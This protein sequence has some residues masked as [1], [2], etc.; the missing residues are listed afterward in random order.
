MLDPELLRFYA[1]LKEKLLELLELARTIDELRY[2]LP[3][4]EETVNSI[5]EIIEREQSS[6]EDKFLLQKP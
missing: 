1:E 6:N 3:Q 2:K 4:L 5:I